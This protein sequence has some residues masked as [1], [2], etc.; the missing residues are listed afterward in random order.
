M[1]CSM[2]TSINLDGSGRQSSG[3][4]N[5]SSVGDRQTDEETEVA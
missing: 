1:I 3:G 4:H 2:Q 5:I